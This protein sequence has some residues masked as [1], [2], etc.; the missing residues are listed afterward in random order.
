VPSQPLVKAAA[1]CDGGAVARRV[2]QAD[3][4]ELFAK[5]GYVDWAGL[6][7][8]SFGFDV[9]RC[10]RCATKMRVFATITHRP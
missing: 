1:H 10:P 4:G 7:K 8:R 6:M 2:R 9:L 5:A 3:D